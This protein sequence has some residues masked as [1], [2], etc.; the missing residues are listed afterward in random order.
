MT[1]N[2]N[3]LLQLVGRRKWWS[4]HLLC[5]FN[6]LVDVLEKESGVWLFT[7]SRDAYCLLEVSMR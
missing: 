1:S 3:S 2:W 6:S 4:C 5:L 7:L